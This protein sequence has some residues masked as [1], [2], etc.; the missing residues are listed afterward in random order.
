MYNIILVCN[1]G[2][3]T[4]MVVKKMQEATEKLS[5]EATIEAIPES[6]LKKVAETANVILLGPQISY[7]LDELKKLYEEKGIKVAVVNGTDYAMM[8]GEKVLKFAIDLIKK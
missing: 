7:K 4:S 2:L 3:S 8:N 1:L 6:S 5:I